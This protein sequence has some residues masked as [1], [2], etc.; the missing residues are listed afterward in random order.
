MA[1]DTYA[2]ESN[3]FIKSDMDTPEEQS[4]FQRESDLVVISEMASPIM[5]QLSVERVRKLFPEAWLCENSE[6]GYSKLNLIK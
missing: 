2:T 5:E 6:A 3:L 4:Y 1:T